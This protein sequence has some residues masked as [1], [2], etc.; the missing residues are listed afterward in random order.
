VNELVEFM[1]S[2]TGVADLLLS[3]EGRNVADRKVIE[4]LMEST[5]ISGDLWILYESTTRLGGKGSVWSSNREVCWISFP[6]PRTSSKAD[7]NSTSDE[8]AEWM[9]GGSYCGV[10]AAPWKSLPLIL[11]ADDKATIMGREPAVPPTTVFDA[12]LIG[13]AI[14]LAGIR[15]CLIVGGRIE[16]RR[17]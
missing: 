6:V 1:T 10:Q 16:H 5:R 12:D 17:C 9:T 3:F 13:H 11:V 14:L 4:P 15:A 7:K 8:A 2:Q